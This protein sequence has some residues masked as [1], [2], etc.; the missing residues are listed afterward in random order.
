M[1]DPRILPPAKLPDPY[2]LNEWRVHRNLAM[3]RAQIE[4]MAAIE[5]AM[6]RG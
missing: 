6:S 1:L 5:E 4:R 2:G 3:A